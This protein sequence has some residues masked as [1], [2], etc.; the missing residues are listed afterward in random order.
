MIFF[1]KGQNRLT[2]ATVHRPV[3]ERGQGSD[4]GNRSARTKGSYRGYGASGADVQRRKCF[5]VNHHAWW[6]GRAVE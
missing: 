4:W 6:G 1:L 2:M 5:P 3:I